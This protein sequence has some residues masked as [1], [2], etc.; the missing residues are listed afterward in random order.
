MSPMVAS[1]PSVLGEVQYNQSF[2]MML[3]QN[4]FK[5]DQWTNRRRIFAG[6][7]GGFALHGGASGRARGCS[8]AVARPSCTHNVGYL[9][10][11]QTL[12][13]DHFK[14]AYSMD[15]ILTPEERTVA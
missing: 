4:K 11:A 2:Q 12:V 3:A 15:A 1:Q 5:G 7:H 14:W 9:L 13:D 8:R 10:H 6:E